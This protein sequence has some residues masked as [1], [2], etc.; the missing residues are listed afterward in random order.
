MQ[1]CFV[2]SV[3]LTKS[4]ISVIESAKDSLIVDSSLVIADE[5]LDI[6][7]VK[8]INKTVNFMEKRLAIK[9][10]R[11]VLKIKADPAT[12]LAL[13]IAL[14][15]IE[16]NNKESIKLAKEALKENPNYFFQSHQ[17]EQLWGE[18]LQKAGIKLFNSPKLKEVLNTASANSN[19]TNEK[20]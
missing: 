18:K 17:E 15:S 8:I 14:Y 2:I 10:W 5:Y 7:Y 4:F 19:F 11:K 12:K 9:I 6:F 16:P 3:L 20:D 13:A 1:E